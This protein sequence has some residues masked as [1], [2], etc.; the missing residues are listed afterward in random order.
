MF[1]KILIANRGEIALRVIRACKEMGVRTVA[2]YSEADRDS[3]HVR[4]AD[5]IVCIGPP[6]A[7][8]SYLNVPRIIS[9]AE[10]T[11][12]EAIHPG[13]GFLAENADFAEACES[14]G[15]KFIGPGADIISRMGDKA[16]A[17]EAMLKAGVPVVPGSLG[18]VDSAG[19]ALSVAREIG[20]PVMIKA[21]GGG[22][23]KGMRLANDDAEL[24]KAFD[25]AAGEAEASFGNR[26]VYLEKLIQSPRHI[27]MQVLCDS[28]GGAVYLGERDCSVQRKHQ[29][30][31]EEA[32]SPAVDEGLRLKLGEAAIR[33]AVSVGYENAGTVEFLMDSGGSFYFIEMNTRIQVEHCVTEMI[34]GIDIVREQIEIAAGE[35]LSVTQKDVVIKG[36]AIECRINAE[37]PDRDFAP[38]PGTID[39]INIPGGPG[40]RVDTHAY[41]QYVIPAFY[42]SLIAK[43]VAYGPDRNRAVERMMRALDEFIIEGVNTTI[44]FHRKAVGSDLFRSGN[45]DTGFVD[46]LMNPGASRKTSEKKNLSGVH[47]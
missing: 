43:V 38:S 19:D 41:A 31:I 6:R 17:R 36:H 8:D 21:S 32:P 3:L 22:G 2:V 24:G 42:D 27:E 9:A 34:T 18:A 12:A 7:S 30:L 46:L 11:G 37:D 16:A 5:E 4:F 25:A 15:L 35:P 45:F 39:A 33:G 44:G 13:Y 29:K 10:V 1:D 28:M 14:C 20:Y 47:T 23:G 26:E 40:I